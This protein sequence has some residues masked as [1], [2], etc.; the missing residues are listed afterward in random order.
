MNA[1]VTLLASR[2]PIPRRMATF[3]LRSLNCLY[4]V[5]KG[6]RL[7]N[8]QES[9]AICSAIKSTFP[10]DRKL[11][12]ADTRA[13]FTILFVATSKDFRV[14]PTAILYAIKSLQNYAIEKVIVYVPEKEVDVAKEL[15]K[16]TFNGIK[17]FTESESSFFNFME[18]SNHFSK[19][20]PGRGAWCS[21]QVL[22]I[23]AVRNV[24]TEYALVVDAD[25]ILINQRPWIDED[26]NV[27]LT[28]SLEYHN[29]YYE[30]LRKIGLELRKPLI[31]FVPHHMV[32]RVSK[33]RSLLAEFSMDSVEKIVNRLDFLDASMGPSPFCIDFELHGQ[34]E[35]LEAKNVR[36]L[37]RWANLSLSY[38]SFKIIMKR[39]HL[40]RVLSTLFNSISVHARPNQ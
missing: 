30:V 3:T 16:K 12:S 13:S 33:V 15:F 7:W 29:Q 6:H 25:T 9:D 37:G 17:V 27:L 21:Q 35:Y 31:S 34:S 14:L 32:Y 10:T 20:F 1:L 19:I 11:K 8:N 2:L 26:G 4:R 39:K 28:P 24:E 40:V 23:L 22:K 18:L 5:I 36:M 38:K